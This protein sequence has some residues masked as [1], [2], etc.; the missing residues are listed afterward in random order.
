MLLEKKNKIKGARVVLLVSYGEGVGGF[1]RREVSSI[2][3]DFGTVDCRIL[4]VSAALPPGRDWDEPDRLRAPD[5]DR[6]CCLGPL[7]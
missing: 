5:E 1:G 7:R 4:H 6:C 2:E 3:F